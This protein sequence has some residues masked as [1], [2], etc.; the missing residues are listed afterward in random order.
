LDI[1][2]AETFFKMLANIAG[3]NRV[4]ANAFVEGC[5]RMKGGATSVDLACLSFQ[6]DLLHHEFK[7]L[8]RHITQLVGDTTV[9]KRR[10]QQQTETRLKLQRSRSGDHWACL[11]WQPEHVRS[12]LSL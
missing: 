3:P 10:Q 12:T 6:T 9:E 5:M 8:S 4:D 1:R 11:D 2:D 7:N